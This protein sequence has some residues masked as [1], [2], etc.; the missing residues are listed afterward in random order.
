MRMI[1]RTLTRTKK[2]LLCVSIMVMCKQVDRNVST[3]QHSKF[4]A[5]SNKKTLQTHTHT[6][7]H[8]VSWR[9]SEA[10]ESD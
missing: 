4:I 5:M 7:K 10:D 8:T 9:A 3:S 1:N 6:H 2:K